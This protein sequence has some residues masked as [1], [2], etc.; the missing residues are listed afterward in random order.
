[1]KKIIKI[2]L[3]VFALFLTVACGDEKVLTTPTNI[4]LVIF[5]FKTYF[6]R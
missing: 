4:V 5:R 1:M 6:F 3:L 2:V